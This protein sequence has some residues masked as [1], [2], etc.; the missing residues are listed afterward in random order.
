MNEEIETKKAGIKNLY[1]HLIAQFHIHD[2]TITKEQLIELKIYLGSEMQ[3][4]VQAEQKKMTDT[5]TH[6]YL[7]DINEAN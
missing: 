5:L 6:S 1:T 7:C 4:T 3:L 2:R